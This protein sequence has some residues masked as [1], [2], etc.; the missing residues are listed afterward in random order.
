MSLRQ[1]KKPS[2]SYWLNSDLFRIPFSIKGD[3][4]IKNNSKKVVDTNFYRCYDIRVAADEVVTRWTLKTE[5][6]KR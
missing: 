4:K 1:N 5:Q 3:I 6:A 2:K